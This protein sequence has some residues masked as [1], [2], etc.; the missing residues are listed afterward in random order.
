AIYKDSPLPPGAIRPLR[1]ALKIGQI[2]RSTRRYF[3]RSLKRR[4]PTRVCVRKKNFGFLRSGR[5]ARALRRSVQ[6]SFALAIAIFADCAVG[7][8]LFD[9]IPL[10]GLAMTLKS[11]NMVGLLVRYNDF[12]INQEA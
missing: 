11:G 5:T 10:P 9:Y 12:R 7:G 6:A 4:A 8:A 3:S 2:V 1:A